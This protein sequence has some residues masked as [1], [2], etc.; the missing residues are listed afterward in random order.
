MW[1]GVCVCYQRAEGNDR[2]FVLQAV[3]VLLRGWIEGH[4]PLGRGKWARWARRRWARLPTKSFG[5]QNKTKNPRSVTRLQETV[6]PPQLPRRSTH[7]KTRTPTRWRSP[8]LPRRPSPTPRPSAA[9]P[10][11]PPSASP[12]W[13][14]TAHHPR[15]RA[16]PQK[17]SIRPN[18]KPIFIFKSLCPCLLPSHPLS[19]SRF[20]VQG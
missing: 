17:S 6:K 15:A 13:Y 5:L 9:G 20:P 16:S 12:P 1:W 2:P 7:T 18:L 11:A 4:T 3:A 19:R 8:W 10:A 14:A